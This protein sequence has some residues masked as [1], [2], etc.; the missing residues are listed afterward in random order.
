MI[1]S[2]S[3]DNTLR[4]WDVETGVCQRTIEGPSGAIIGIAISPLSDYV[5]SC[6]VSA[7][8]RVWNIKTGVCSNTLTGHSAMIF[9]VAF[10]PRGDIVA[11]GSR[12][13][14]VRLWDVATGECLK[15][16]TG[17]ED[18]ISAIEFSP[19]GDH[20]ISTDGTIRLWDV[21]TGECIR[22]ITYGDGAYKV[23]FSPQGDVVGSSCFDASVIL[24]DV[25]TESLRHVL[26]GHTELVAAIAFSPKGNLVVTA[27]ETVRI[28]DVVSGQCRAIIP[29]LPGQSYGVDWSRRMDVNYIVN[30]CA[31]GS[32]MM[33]EVVEDQDQCHVQLRWTG[34]SGTLNL[35]NTS[36]Q[37]VK[38]L[39]HVNKQLFKQRGATG[40]PANL[41]RDA[42]KSMIRMGSILSNMKLPSG[43]MS[44]ASSSTVDTPADKLGSRAKEP[45]QN[46]Q[47][48]GQI[49]ATMVDGQSGES[50]ELPE[51]ELIDETGGED[52]QTEEQVGRSGE[53]EEMWTDEEVEDV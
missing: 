21:E 20:L 18:E 26:E 8:A 13:T 27:S 5:V 33:W 43:G 1:I 23:A 14:T 49:E 37:D 15:T 29:N 46:E 25:Q 7:T 48:Q 34:S 31:D 38:G 16:L 40:E 10:S 36:I 28:W 42:S 41:F 12:D 47:K 52:M 22:S 50:I 9:D 44:M 11:T 17:H 19:K 24:W 4:L 3:S 51:S 2:S 39:S 53:D 30:G 45:E 32:V 6:N 35:T